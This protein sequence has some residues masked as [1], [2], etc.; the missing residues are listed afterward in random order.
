GPRNQRRTPAIPSTEYKS[1]RFGKMSNVIVPFWTPARPAPRN[2]IRS[3][4]S[5]RLSRL[6]RRS[7]R[8]SYGTSTFVT[9]GADITPPFIQYRGL[10]RDSGLRSLGTAPRISATKVQVTPRSPVCKPAARRPNMQGARSRRRWTDGRTRDNRD[11]GRWED[12]RGPRARTP[13]RPRRAGHADPRERC[14]SVS[15]Q[16]SRRQ[17]RRR[18]HRI[19]RRTG[20]RVRPPP[21]GA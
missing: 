18:T 2:V 19:D 17:A 4:H 13:R 20:G 3:T 15:C 6:P 14:G 10:V 11:R 1:G 5:S 7:I 12:G 16:R 9:V 21:T 8:S